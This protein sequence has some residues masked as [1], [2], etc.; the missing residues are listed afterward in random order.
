[1]YLIAIIK[2]ADENSIIQG[3]S[4]VYEYLQF[5]NL[6][7]H[8]IAA[9]H[10][11]LKTHDAK[12]DL[13]CYILEVIVYC[14]MASSFY[15]FDGF[16]KHQ[17]HAFRGWVRTCIQADRKTRWQVAGGTFRTW[18]TPRRA[19]ADVLR[20]RHQEIP[21]KNPTTSLKYLKT[22]VLSSNI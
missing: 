3:V 6:F 21:N 1:M 5:K 18:T 12:V 14:E 20:Q 10:W 15:I 2:R 8:K 22:C 4:L 9:L 7:N 11:P 13:W 19:P 16:L 17:A